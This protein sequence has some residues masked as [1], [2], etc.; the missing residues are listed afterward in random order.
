MRVARHSYA[1]LYQHPPGGKR[2]LEEDEAFG[3]A[4]RVMADVYASAVG[5][6]VLQVKEI[7]PRPKDHDGALCLF[8][9]VGGADEAAIRA[10]LVRFGEIETVELKSKTAIVWFTSHA[11]AVEAKQV[12]PPNW[13]CEALDLLYNERS[14]DGRSKGDGGRSDDGGRGWCALPT[15]LPSPLGV[16]QPLPRL[17]VLKQVLL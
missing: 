14:Y 11:A 17:C 9:L 13:L 10:A 1:S 6:T 12:P 5:T 7:P 8:G 2:T 3:R 15:E 4:L 16:A